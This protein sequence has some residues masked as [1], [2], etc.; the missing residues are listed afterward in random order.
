MKIKRIITKIKKALDTIFLRGKIS[1][2]QSGED[3]IADY[4]FEQIGIGKPKY[5][6]I[7]ANQPIKGNNTYY[8]YQ[9]GANGICIEPDHSL[10][11]DLKSKRPNDII[12]NIG[13][14]IKDA[15]NAEFYYFD[16]HYNAWNTF[17]KIDAEKKKKESGI[18]YN[19]TKVNLE[20]IHNVIERYN[21]YDVNFISIDVEGLDLEILKS[22][23]F[24]KINPELICVE[25][26]LFSLQNGIN[27]NESITS[28]ML[29]QNYIVY[30][31]TNLNTFFC[32]KDLFQ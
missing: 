3:L 9:K 31:D 29:D 22:I 18:S 6:D 24:K 16:G 32:R 11:Q 19:T 20:N 15:Q 10:I 12:L 5:I 17:S 30:A 25:T 13:I 4:F 27:K 1:Y 23:N 14:S 2:S 28:Y 21:F 8:F 7:G 26:I